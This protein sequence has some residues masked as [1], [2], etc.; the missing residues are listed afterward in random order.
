MDDGN[1]RTNMRKLPG[2]ASQQIRKKRDV[3]DKDDGNLE[4]WSKKLYLDRP[5]EFAD[6]SRDIIQYIQI[7]LASITQLKAFEMRPEGSKNETYRHITQCNIAPSG[8]GL[9]EILKIFD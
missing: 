7:Y 1:C 8:R 3:N 4:S 2:S 6:L 9:N 5:G